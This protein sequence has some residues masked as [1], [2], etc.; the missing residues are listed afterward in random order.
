MIDNIK[1]LRDSTS[2]EQLNLLLRNDGAGKFAS[3]GPSSGPGF[4]MKKPAALSPLAISTTTA[5]W[6]SWSPMS[7]QRPMCFRMT[8]AIAELHSYADPRLDQ[9]P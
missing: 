7:A 2:Y 8:G 9:Q 6:T 5:T 4:A 1:R 3:V